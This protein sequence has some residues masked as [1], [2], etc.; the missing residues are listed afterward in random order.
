MGKFVNGTEFVVED[1]CTCG[2]QFAMT[3]D[4]Q[5][6]K[7]K[8]RGW[9]CCPAGHQQYYA[10]KTEEQKLREQIEQKDREIAARDR[11]VSN[12]ESRARAVNKQYKRIRDRVKN[13]VCPCC[14][15]TF[16]NLAS[17]MKTEHQDFGSHDLLKSLRVAYGMTQANL[18]EELWIHPQ[19]ISLYENNKPSV[20]DHAVSKI[21]SWLAKQT[22]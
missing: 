20:S 5:R 8:D 9:F 14:N 13:G 19:Q 6:R 17:H 2:M 10:G 21:E 7:L 18:A 4:F 3:V 16:Q 1:C 22:A 11:R 12:A 15:R